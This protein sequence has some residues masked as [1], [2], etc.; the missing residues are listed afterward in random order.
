MQSTTIVAIAAAVTVSLSSPKAPV[1]A[2]VKVT[3]TTCRKV[4]PTEVA[5][6][7]G[8]SPP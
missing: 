8:S 5:W 7:E 1:A 6:V 3:C 2:A 4:A